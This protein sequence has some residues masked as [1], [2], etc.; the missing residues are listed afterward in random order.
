MNIYIPK[1]GLHIDRKN[2]PQVAS[3][4]MPDLL[5]FIKSEGAEVKETKIKTSALQPSQ[6][7][8]NLD[9]VSTLMHDE[10]SNLAKHVLIS[11]DNYLID[12]HHRWLA[13]LNKDKN[14]LINA[15]KVNLNVQDLISLVKRF[16]KVFYKTIKEFK[17]M[18]KE[19]INELFVTHLNEGINDPSIF[20]AVFLFGGPGSGKDFILSKVLLGHGLV[21]INSDVAF[22]YL[23]KKHNLSLKMPDTEKV[24]RDL[25]RGKS[26]QTTALKQDL[27]IKGRLGIIING[28]G[29]DIEK[30]QRIKKMLEA[31]GYDTMGIFVNTRNEVSQQRNVERGIRGGRTVPEEIRQEKWSEVQKAIPSTKKIFGE[32]N[33]IEF[34][35]SEDL[36]RASKDVV[37]SKTE[38]LQKIFKKV[39]EFTQ[40]QPSSPLAHKW[41]DEQKRKNS[42]LKINEDFATFL[43][44]KEYRERPKDKITGENKKDVSGLS[45]ETKLKR[46]AHWD[47]ME[48]KTD[49]DP[50][51]YVPAPGDTEESRKNLKKSEYT[52]AYEKM[53]GESLEEGTIESVKNKAKETGIS[54]SI[55]KQVYNRGMAAWKGSHRPGTTP[56]QWA[57]ARINSFA[58]GGKTRHTA[59]ADLWKKVRKENFNQE[60]NENE[61]IQENYQYI[62][63]AIDR[64]SFFE[65]YGRKKDSRNDRMETDGRDSTSE[66]NCGTGNSQSSYGKQRRVIKE[67]ENLDTETSTQ[68]T[69][70]Y[71]RESE[72]ESTKKKFTKFKKQVN[73]AE[74]IENI[75]QI[76]DEE[77]D[78]PQTGVFGYAKEKLDRLTGKATTV[79]EALDYHIENNIPL[80]K[81]VFR[82]MSENYFELINHA[83]NLHENGLVDIQDEF[84]IELLNSDIGKFDLYEGET[85][86]LDLPLME[87]DESDVELNKPKR[88]GSK[89]FYV[90]VKDTDTGNVKKIS[91]GDTTGL[92]TKINDPEARKNFAARH[93]CDQK[94]DKTTPGYWACR[95]PRYADSLGL[96]GGNKSY[97]W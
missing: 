2:M 80:H 71:T 39:R 75:D 9:K 48:K 55:L 49:S 51:A 15:Y 47:R 11:N 57:M 84:D 33:F 43:N 50:S 74:V 44:E 70:Q 87:E 61:Y 38:Q 25:I 24:E 40:K 58:T 34:D 63:E 6:G 26:K 1:S 36:R 41:M 42:R 4:D 91:F 65:S 7:N 64:E 3:K 32:M 81:N 93:N 66:S 97:F 23:L 60:E 18:D 59:D 52:K 10:T 31:L 28:T 69:E 35:N 8:M 83:R 76:M 12:G 22:E 89:K 45:K 62:C 94:N 46:S 37:K 73:K 21:E 5:K 68:K 96:A 20:K 27:T 77:M 17:E 85:V 30:T 95:I 16:P 72:E 29:D 67:K 19:S 14:S 78:E 79:T 56:Q 92:S 90:F 82:Y 86:P 54:Y 88:G 13:L 53:Y